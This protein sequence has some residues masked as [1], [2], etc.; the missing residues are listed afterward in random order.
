[1]SWKFVFNGANLIGR[2]LCDIAEIAHSVGYD[3]FTF[4]GEVYFFANGSI[5]KTHITVK[6][7]S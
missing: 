3:F 7:L 5:H 2:T 6:D 4:N 1:M